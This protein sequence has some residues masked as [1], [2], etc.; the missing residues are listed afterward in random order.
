MLSGAPPVVHV[1][2]KSPETVRRYMYFAKNTIAWWILARKLPHLTTQICGTMALLMDR[3]PKG[4]QK[5]LFL[6]IQNAMPQGMR[7]DIH[8][9]LL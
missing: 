7:Y 8:R 6:E 3:Q 9:V 4:I 5:N 2:S 1:D